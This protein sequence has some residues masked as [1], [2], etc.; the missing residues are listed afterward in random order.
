M[1]E[2]KFK[3]KLV[4]FLI[5]LGKPKR[6]EVGFVQGNRVINDGLNILGLNAIDIL[7][8]A[9]SANK[10]RSRKSKGSQAWF[11]KMYEDG[12]RYVANFEQ[13]GLLTNGFVVMERELPN[14]TLN[15]IREEFETLLRDEKKISIVAK[16]IPKELMEMREE[17]IHKIVEIN[18]D[19]SPTV[20][21][22]D[23]PFDFGRDVKK[24]KVISQED[25]EKFHGGKD[26]RVVSQEDY[27]KFHKKLEP[28]EGFDSEV[29]D[30]IIDSQK[31]KK[32]YEELFFE[33]TGK[34]AVWRG[35]NTIA[36]K[37]WLEGLD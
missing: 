3:E 29:N 8:F 1:N 24:P 12:W 4:E 36:F 9:K 37:K 34:N 6:Y 26:P 31:E 33:E 5:E 2:K 35:K 27:E 21:F 20:T 22:E 18:P 23:K 11:K 30:F 32:T 7:G 16:D 13:E 10:S 15:I 14:E 25:Y 19:K 28:K 17:Y